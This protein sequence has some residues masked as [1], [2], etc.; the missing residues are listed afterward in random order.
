MTTQENFVKITV[1]LADGKES[2]WKLASEESYKELVA[3]IGGELVDHE[4]YNVLG[5]SALEDGVY[6]LSPAM[7][8]IVTLELSL[9][10]KTK[11]FSWKKEDLTMASLE[12]FVREKFDIPL[13]RLSFALK[14]AN[15]ELLDSDEKLDSIPADNTTRVTVIVTRVGFSSILTVKEALQLLHQTGDS[16][17]ISDSVF[18]GPLQMEENNEELLHAVSTLQRLHAVAPLP[19]GCEATRRLYIDPILLAA[20][21]VAGPDVLLEVE[22]EYENRDVWG[23]IDY[24][25]KHN[26]ETI[27][28]TEGKKDQLDRGVVQNIAQLAAVADDRKRKREI[29]EISSEEKPIYGI[30]TTYLNWQFLVL[31]DGMVSQSSIFSIKDAN[32]DDVG[33]IIGRIVSILNS[34][35]GSTK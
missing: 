31:K 2:K 3:K 26:G 34:G 8:P 28:V 17:P 7:E 15:D 27:C 11:Y 30:A 14:D 24:V 1:A 18:P 22:K 6:T 19:Q 20:A 13:A 35:K 9:K 10:K 32:R 16:I 12:L 4:G 5:F 29:S 23:P 25:F 21:R 33:G